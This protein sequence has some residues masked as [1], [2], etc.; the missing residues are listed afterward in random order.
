MA[1]EPIAV[2]NSTVTLVEAAISLAVGFHMA[3]LNLDAKELALVMAVVVAIGNMVKTLW[4]R[5]QVTPVADPKNDQG[6]RL[7]PQKA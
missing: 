6:E 3:G 2:V 5:G 7:I 1:S 4:S